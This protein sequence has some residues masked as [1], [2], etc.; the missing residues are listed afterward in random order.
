MFGVRNETDSAAINETA[1]P[2]GALGLFRAAVC[3]LFDQSH[4]FTS[5]VRLYPGR[6]ELSDALG[7]AFAMGWAILWPLA[8]YASLSSIARAITG[9]AWNGPRFFGGSTRGPRFHRRDH[10]ERRDH[11]QLVI[12]DVSNDLRLLR[13]HGV[14]CGAS[15]AVDG[16]QNC[17]MI[18]SA[19][20]G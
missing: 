1:R 14:E 4:H 9:T 19:R 11:Q 8:T 16:F 15:G 20:F 12:V 18:G 7:K 17:A 10:D 5:L 13:D 3:T 2:P 6:Q